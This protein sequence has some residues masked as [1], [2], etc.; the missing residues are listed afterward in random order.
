MSII[1]NEQQKTF[2]LDAQ[3]QEFSSFQQGDFRTSSMEVVNSDGSLVFG[4][5]VK[6]YSIRSGKYMLKRLPSCFSTEADTADTLEITL[7]DAVSNVEVTLLYGV[8]EERDII[9]RAAIVKNAGS[10]PIHLNKI[11]S[12]CLDFPNG[13]DKELISFYGRYGQ[14]K[15][16]ERYPLT[17]HIHRFESGRGSSSHQQTPFMILC[18]HDTTEDFGNCCGMAL[19]YSGNFLAEAEFD[20]YDQLRL[21]IGINNKNFHYLIESGETFVAPEV[22]MT[23]TDKGLSELSHIYHDFIR[24]VNVT[25]TNQALVTGM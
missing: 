8:F 25:M 16:V 20:Q 3:L 5:R 24:L 4:G 19:M 23:C 22:V 1:Y 7:V 21:Q 14:E 15:Q 9:T 2:S 6:D 12:A 17:H 13:S 18:D 10:G 11:M